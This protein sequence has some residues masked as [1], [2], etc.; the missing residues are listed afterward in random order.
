MEVIVAIISGLCVAIPSI[1]STVIVNNRNKNLL[2]YRVGSLEEKVSKHNNLIDR[3][4]KV[5][6]RVTVLEDEIRR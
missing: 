2:I 1:I 3:M 5:E 4:Y 6:S